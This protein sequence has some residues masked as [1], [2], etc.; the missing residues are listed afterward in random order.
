MTNDDE[1]R[2]LHARMM[3]MKEAAALGI[4]RLRKPVWADPLDHMKIDI[5]DGELGPWMHLYAPFNQR[6][7]HDPVDILWSVQFGKDSASS[8]EFVVY[9][10]P[11]P[12]SDVYKARQAQFD[13]VRGDTE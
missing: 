4:E 5:V 7:G 13:G 8:R 9:D 11:L 10:G 12:D 2:E 6:T 1:V 3:S